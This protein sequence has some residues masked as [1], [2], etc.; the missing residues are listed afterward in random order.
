MGT[1]SDASAGGIPSP[2]QPSATCYIELGQ[3][4]STPINEREGTLTSTYEMEK[5]TV[6]WDLLV[7]YSCN[8]YIDA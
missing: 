2:V 8:V 4:W 1:S 7:K 6:P 3:G 5:G